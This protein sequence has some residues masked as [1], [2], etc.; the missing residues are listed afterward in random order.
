MGLSTFASLAAGAADVLGWIVAPSRCSACDELTPRLAVF[1]G[2]CASTAQRADNPRTDD[3]AALVYGGAVQQ[4]VTRFKYERRPD[5]ARPLG[6][7]LW[8]AVEPHAAALRGAVVVPVPLHPS[9]LAERGYNQSALLARRVAAG[10]RSP[11][12]PLALARG[13]DTPRQA[14]LDRKAR[15]SNVSG[16]FVTRQ[17][18]RLDGRVVLLIDD[19]RTTGATLQ[20]CARVVSAAGAA[21][22]VTAVLARAE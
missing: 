5:L 8:R 16:A 2:G 14:T 18:R 4:A 22:V 20:A 6:D 17:P 3:L 13:R 11:F 12:L 9:R 15:A 7:L 21:D 10:L 1:C 19:V